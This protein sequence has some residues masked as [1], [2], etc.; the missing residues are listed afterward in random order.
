[1]HAFHDGRFDG[2][3][4]E[5]AASDV[6]VEMLA[7]ELV[8]VEPRRVSDFEAVNDGLVVLEREPAAANG[9]R[10]F[11]MPVGKNRAH[12]AGGGRRDARAMGVAVN[13]GFGF[14]SKSGFVERPLVDVGDVG[15]LHGLAAAASR[16][17]IFDHLQALFDG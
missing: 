13:D 5:F 10:A 8:A 2:I 12:N 15:G 7:K 11:E 9:F 4:P 17:G 3:L 14:M 16:T 6:R 1:M